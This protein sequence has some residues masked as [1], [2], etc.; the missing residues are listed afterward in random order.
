VKNLLRLGLVLACATAWGYDFAAL[1]PQGYVSDFAQALDAA[2]RQRLERASKLLEEA[3]GVQLALVTLP[4]LAGEPIEDVANTLFRKWGIGQ[5]GKNDGL[6]L[7]LVPPERRFRLEVG[8]GLEEILPDGYSGSL[9]R[10]MGPALRERRYGEALEDAVA[11]LSS[12]IAQAKGVA[13]EQVPRPRRPRQ[14]ES[15]FP[16]L[17]AL[18]GLAVFGLLTGLIGRRAARRGSGGLLPGLIIGAILGRSFGSSS[19]GG[20]FGGFDSGDSFGGFGGGD[21][22][23]GG[24]S[25]SW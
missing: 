24:A 11:E 18:A 19:D 12:R 13:L 15:P 22:G 1:K 2:S 8:Y 23:G 4:A 5:K 16:L 10:S 7:L 21:S 17:A 14:Q 25:G 3:T 20:G 6:L 9:L